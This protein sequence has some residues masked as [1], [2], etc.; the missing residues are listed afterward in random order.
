M[1]KSNEFNSL[2]EMQ[3]NDALSKYKIIEPYLN[4]KLSLSEV[5]NET[6]IPIRTL[7]SWNNRFNQFG[8]MG[9]VRK[10]RRDKGSS[11]KVEESTIDI[12]KAL[13]LKYSKLSKSNIHK[14]IIE[15]CEKNNIYIPSY[16][17]V[18]NIINNIPKD[19][20]CLSHEGTKT[21]KEKYDLLLMRECD[22]PN[23]IWQAD[24]VMLDIEILNSKSRFERPW[25][26]IIMDDYS[27][28]ICGYELSFLSPS[29]HKTSL[30]LRHAIWRKTDPKWIA[31]GVPD[32]LYTDHGSDF[33][34]K[35][36][37]QVCINLKIDLIFSQ[38]GQPRGRGKIERFF[39]TINQELISK[40]VAINN[41]NNSFGL[42]QLDIYIIEFINN[43]N[44]RTHSS[45]K[46]SPNNKWQDNGFIPNILSSLESLDLLLFTELKP[47]KVRQDGI[48]FQG[49][50]YF[51]IILASYI[52][53]EVV[54]RYHPSDISSIRIYYKNE[55]LCQPV[56]NE[57]SNKKVSIKEIIQIRNARRKEL[58]QEITQRLSYADSVIKPYKNSVI[59]EN[60]TPSKEEKPRIRLYENE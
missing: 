38:V 50:V 43:Y 10:N 25:L 27:R 4:K 19:L 9:L 45:I 13:Y 37:E 29:S 40:I 34:S 23:Q 51:D 5:S 31:F 6:K 1:T 55:Y 58:K 30:C 21:Y 56:S 22:R 18:R 60:I 11:R 12:V 47:R 2:T 20:T 57:F 59:A 36:I 15:H 54:I 24:H 28:A 53:K 39:R 14:M 33:T 3:R 35:H 41:K 42:E 32:K 17:T 52:G 44:I 16:T 8:F 46:M 26:T 49:L 7:N 48:H